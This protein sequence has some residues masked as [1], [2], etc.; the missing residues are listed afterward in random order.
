MFPN[1]LPRV[2]IGYIVH[3]SSSWLIFFSCLII[4]IFSYIIMI[5][6]IHY[7][8]KNL[9]ISSVTIISYIIV[10]DIHWFQS[11]DQVD[12]GWVS[13]DSVEFRFGW[14]SDRL[15]FECALRQVTLGSGSVSHN[16][17]EDQLSELS[18][19]H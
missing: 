9:K 15:F 18:N 1:P 4:I 11:V 14:T 16:S 13:F 5:F 7:T 10:R 8:K 6:L 3:L 12:F 19:L 2:E 17:V